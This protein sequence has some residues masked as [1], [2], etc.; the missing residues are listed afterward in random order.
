MATLAQLCH[1]PF[2]HA[3][4]IE[5][6]SSPTFR[7][8]R[9]DRTHRE[10]GRLQEYIAATFYDTYGAQV[11]HFCDT[12]VG[13]CDEDGRWV[14]A[15]GFTCARD[16]G[17]FLEQYLDASLEHEIAARTGAD[18]NRSQIVE[19]GNL[20]ASHAGA[21]RKLIACM[22]EYLYHQGVVWVAF[23]ATRGLL[24]SFTRLRLRPTVIVDADP[25]RL[26]DGGKNWGSYYSTKPQ[27]MFGDIRSGYAQLAK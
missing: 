11:S 1:S 18:V 3:E 13:C 10:R 26:P 12:L 21:A 25:R 2:T 22:T 5:A 15:L 8:E 16:G 14:A 24:N 19:V 6:G 7:S 27:V 9:V 17:I 20:A 23:T 4:D